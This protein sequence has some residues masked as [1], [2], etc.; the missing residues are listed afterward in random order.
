MQHIQY[1]CLGPQRGI[2]GKSEFFR[3]AVRGDKADPENV[4]GKTVGILLHHRD[5]IVSILLENL[6]GITG[7][8]PV[9]LEK[10]HHLP[11]FLLIL[12]GFPD[13]G[14]ALFPDALHLV[15]G[16]NFILND[17]QRA[18]TEFGHNTLG[19]LRPD[20]FDQPGPQVFSDTIDSGRNSSIIK[21][22]LELLP[23][24]GMTDPLALHFE[25][26]PGCRSHEVS[27]H[28]DQVPLPIDLQPGN[29]VAVFLVGICDAFNLALKINQH[30]MRSFKKFSN[31]IIIFLS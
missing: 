18:F 28:R 8:D 9:G 23:V 4:H 6:G 19:N 13:H 1:P 20:T 17:I 31:I 2:F 27:H 14:N 5:G 30:N 21:N 26:F 24:L 3:N 10:E 15:Q 7:T 11:D 25:N 22:N 12:P 16:F 29:G